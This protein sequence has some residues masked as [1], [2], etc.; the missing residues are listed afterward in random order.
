MGTYIE[1]NIEI[2]TL[3]KKIGDKSRDLLSRVNKM[4]D[5]SWMYGVTRENRIINI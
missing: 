2:G 4:R 1:L 3:F 5:E